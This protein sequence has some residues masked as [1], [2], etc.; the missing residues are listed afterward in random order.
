[1][2]LHLVR[3]VMAD[4]DVPRVH[5]A[6]YQA[7]AI[8]NA[9]CVQWLLEHGADPGARDGKVG[10]RCCSGEGACGWRLAWASAGQDAG[11]S[12]AGGGAR[13]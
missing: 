5:G 10:P 7:T 3:V 13:R 1:M 12:C 8:G 4:R 11:G 2:P 9:V 6:P